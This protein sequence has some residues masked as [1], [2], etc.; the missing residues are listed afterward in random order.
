MMEPI[1]LNAVRAVA[2]DVAA[3]T[4]GTAVAA[5]AVDIAGAAADGRAALA[6]AA[7]D[8]A[9]AA[10]DVAAVADTAGDLYRGACGLRLPLPPLQPL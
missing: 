8:T 1:P 6:G 4:T 5:L 3:D 2:A 7:A 10:A 9:V